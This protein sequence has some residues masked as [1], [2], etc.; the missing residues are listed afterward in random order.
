MTPEGKVKAKVNRALATLPRCFKHMPVMNGL[1]APGLD[2]WCCVNGRF[3]GIE[4]KVKGKT[5]TPRQKCTKEQVE[6]AGGKVF[7]V[8]DD[9]TLETMMTYLRSL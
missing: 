7:M 2:Y 5:F 1:G 4:T 3:I 6:A 8:D 9:D